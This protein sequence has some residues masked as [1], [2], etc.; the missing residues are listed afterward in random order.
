MHISGE[1]FK[2]GHILPMLYL[3]QCPTYCAYIYAC[4]LMCVSYS[5]DISIL[6]YI[7]T[8]CALAGLVDCFFY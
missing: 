4:V 8:V 1:C 3:V 6:L 2:T 7:E 5:T